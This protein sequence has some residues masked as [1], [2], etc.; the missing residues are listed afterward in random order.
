M[1][2]RGL[3]LVS[4]FKVNIEIQ[5]VNSVTVMRSNMV[6]IASQYPTSILSP[7]ILVQDL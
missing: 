3:V 1:D 6:R 5:C 4:F 7:G 2:I